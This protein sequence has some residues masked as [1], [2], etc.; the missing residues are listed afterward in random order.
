MNTDPYVRFRTATGPLRQRAHT[1]PAVLRLLAGELSRHQLALLTLQMY[2]YVKYTKVLFE[3]ALSRVDAGAEHEPLRQML[4]YFAEDEA[5]H[6]LVALRDLESMGYDPN[7]CAATLPLPAALNL[8]GANR[9][10]VEEYGPYYLVGE[11]FATETV[12]A[13]NSRRIELAY[14]DVAAVAFYALH[15]EAD[16]GHAAVSERILVHALGL[17]DTERPIML[18]YATAVHNLQ[19]LAEAVVDSHLYPA[20]FQLPS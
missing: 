8:H 14:R 11:T 4:R 13:E 19:R 20:A 16:V 5:G 7:A 18:G 1:A 3:Y 12:G 15:A 9:L 2:H 6:E 10:A 17:R